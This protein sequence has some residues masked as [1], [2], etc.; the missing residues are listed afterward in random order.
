MK[1]PSLFIYYLNNS[2][3]EI[4]CMKKT[5]LAYIGMLLISQLLLSV[6]CSKGPTVFSGN[7]I[8]GVT[9]SWD[10]SE[11]YQITYDSSTA[12]SYAISV[13]DTTF[14]FHTKNSYQFE[15]NGNVIYT[16]YSVVPNT[17][18]TGTYYTS[19]LQPGPYYLVDTSFF[20]AYNQGTEGS[21]IMQFPLTSP[22]TLDFSTPPGTTGTDTQLEFRQDIHSPHVY[23]RS[24]HYYSAY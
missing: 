11:F 10:N 8:V 18:K 21:V 6:T 14:S 23:I 22:D 15:S 16:D 4:A 2:F 13:Y 20:D 17:I 9:G 7:T 5:V 3:I 12:N 1:L 24:I 19:P